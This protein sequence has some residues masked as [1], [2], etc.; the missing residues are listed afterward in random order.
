MNCEIQMLIN[1]YV[2][3]YISP[4][5]N[6]VKK[7]VRGKQVLVFLRLQVNVLSQISDR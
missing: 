4:V 6:D 1:I 5:A 2:T 3:G 7:T